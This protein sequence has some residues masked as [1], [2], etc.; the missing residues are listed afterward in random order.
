MVE[1][2]NWRVIFVQ[3]P[4]LVTEYERTDKGITDSQD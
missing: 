1:L 3:D 2:W 4:I